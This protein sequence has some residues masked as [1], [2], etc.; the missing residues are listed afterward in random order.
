MVSIPADVFA[1]IE[2]LARRTGKSRNGLIS[3]AVRDYLAKHEPVEH[4]PAEDGSASPEPAPPDC[5]PTETAQP[6]LAQAESDSQPSMAMG[7]D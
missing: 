3:E 6:E 1:R 7:H 2:R 5:G 4:A